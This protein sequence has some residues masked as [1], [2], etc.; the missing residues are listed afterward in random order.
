MG[1]PQPLVPEAFRRK[2]VTRLN[3]RK[4]SNLKGNQFNAKR[5][6]Q[7]IVLAKVFQSQ[8][9]FLTSPGALPYQRARR[10]SARLPSDPARCDSVVVGQPGKADSK[11]IRDLV[12]DIQT[13]DQ[14][15]HLFDDPRVRER[16]SV[17]T[18]QTLDQRT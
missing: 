1:G 7:A 12:A 2:N 10:P 16:S 4:S 11:P 18:T 15:G 6:L 3:S 8:S 5:R 13:D 14:G 9:D 17:E